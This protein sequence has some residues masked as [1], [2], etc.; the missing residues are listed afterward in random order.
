MPGRVSL[1]AARLIPG[2]A[3]CGIGT[4]PAL[5][6]GLL[7]AQVTLAG[8]A[9]VYR[10]EDGD[11]VVFSDTP[12]SPDAEPQALPEAISVV[13]PADD[14]AAIAEANRAWLDA[15][16][17]AL[18]ERRD[19][20][21]EAAAAEAPRYVPVAVHTLPLRYPPVAGHR[22]PNR[23]HVGRPQDHGGWPNGAY[24]REA[25]RM[26]R[27]TDERRRPISALSGRQ[28]GARRDEDG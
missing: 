21:A 27:A 4:V 16:R 8:E 18:E 24:E 12:C 19:R 28:L 23:D 9:T 22:W 5:V 20:K 17:Q 2:P 6:A 13:A 3:P 11:T 14:L 10:C 1:R 26:P 25:D 7:F 15:H